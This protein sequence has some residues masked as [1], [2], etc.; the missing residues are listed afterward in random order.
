MHASLDGFIEGLDG[1]LDWI[2]HWEDSRLM[3]QV[4][5]CVLGAD[6]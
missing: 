5:T 4:D 6:M 2:E 1:E 3:A